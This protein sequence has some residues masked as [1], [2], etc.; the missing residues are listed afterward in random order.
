MREFLED[1]WPWFLVLGWWLFVM[2]IGHHRE[3]EAWIGG[4]L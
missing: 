2:A 4:A 1:Y 3:I